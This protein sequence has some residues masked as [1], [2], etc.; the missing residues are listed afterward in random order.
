MFKRSSAYLD[1]HLRLSLM[2]YFLFVPIS[3]MATPFAFSFRD[4]S[5]PFL[6]LIGI[7]ALITLLSFFVYWALV[8][9]MNITKLAGNAGISLLILF[10]TGATR[11]VFFFSLIDSLGIDNPS[12]LLSRIT[13]SVFTVV[14]WL[15][16]F[17]ILIES[18]QRFKR[19]YHALLTQLLILKLRD[20]DSL[21]PGYAHMAQH[22]AR[23]QLKIKDTIQD[24]KSEILDSSDAERLAIALRDEIEQGLRPLS[25][26][27]WV[28]SIFAP[29]VAKIRSIVKTSVTELSYPFLLTA[30]LYALANIV[31][32]TQSLGFLTGVNFALVT[33]FLFYLVERFRTA[34]CNK[35]P[36][37]RSSVNLLFV[38]TIGLL[39]GIGANLFFW[40]L[41]LNYSFI[42]AILSAPSLTVLI[43]AIAGIRLALQDRESMIEIL[44][45]KVINERL[46]NFDL[47]SHAN[48]ASYIHN[49]LQAEL[50]ALALQLDVLSKN[51]DPDHNT[52][53][54]E[55][56]Q[57]LVSQSKS[58]DFKNFLE[59]PE[60]RLIRIVASWD[61]IADISLQL[62][63]E[64]WRDASRSSIV[65]S[66]IQEAIANSV[67]SGRAT[68]VKVESRVE[69]D[70]I[71]LTISDN[72]KAALKT[73]RRGIGSQWIDRVAISEW[74]L[75][76]TET[77]R[78]LRVEI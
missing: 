73:E 72:G 43:I 44:S 6:T 41:N 32:T 55:R 2:G 71:F 38:S 51:P 77:G 26:R 56:L 22:I 34:I 76:Q 5:P 24:R 70:S 33:T 27:L 54:M 14:F 16:T 67:R 62:P 19:R 11:G 17:S 9:L 39:V 30:I 35:F 25:Q 52:I 10:L 4:N 40:A 3:I 69:S 63:S 64:I 1:S 7:G 31:N 47:V 60:K 66:L 59:T 12:T 36:K 65:V 58:E 57:A 49:S 15:G 42:I 50:T 78:V 53:V 29:P 20:S 48:A 13:N 74:K 28:K 45:H 75:E 21:Q 68:E 37:F 18:N 61:G 8:S 46:G 23:M